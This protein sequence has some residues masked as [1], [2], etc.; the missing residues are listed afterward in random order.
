MFDLNI[1]CGYGVG[2]IFGF[3]C[4]FVLNYFEGDWW[5]YVLC[6]YYD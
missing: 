4:C 1:D 5:G 2:K 3:D 6:F